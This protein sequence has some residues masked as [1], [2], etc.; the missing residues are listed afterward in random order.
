MSV[1]FDFQGYSVLVTGGVGGIG[2]KCCL[3]FLQAGA[4]VT[5]GDVNSQH[6]SELMEEVKQV[7]DGAHLPML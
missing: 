2:R 6:G 7:S 1:T 5:C 3:A 4:S